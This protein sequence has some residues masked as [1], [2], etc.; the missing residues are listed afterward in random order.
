MGRL[1]ERYRG[2][3]LGVPPAPTETTCTL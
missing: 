2:Q 1:P 3:E